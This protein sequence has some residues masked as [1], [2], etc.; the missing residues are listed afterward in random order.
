MPDRKP[1][2]IS[3]KLMHLCKNPRALYGKYNDV[4]EYLRAEKLKPYWS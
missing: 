4:I 2:T 1:E 3:Q